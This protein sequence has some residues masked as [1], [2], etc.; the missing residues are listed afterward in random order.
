MAFRTVFWT[1]AFAA[2]FLLSGR[3]AAQGMALD[4]CSDTAPCAENYVCC[5]L[6]DVHQWCLL[7]MS[8]VRHLCLQQ[9]GPKCAPKD[10]PCDAN[11]PWYNPTVDEGEVAEGEVADGEE[12]EGEEAEGVLAEDASA[13][14]G[15]PDQEQSEAEQPEEQAPA[16]DNTTDAAEDETQCVDSST[17]A[18]GTVCCPASAY[19]SLCQASCN[20]SLATL[21]ADC[22]I[23]KGMKGRGERASGTTL[24]TDDGSGITLTPEVCTGATVC[25]SIDEGYVVTKHLC[26]G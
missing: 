14:E 24:H 9:Q 1:C 16:D 22:F 19:L 12:A 26:D 23:V 7:F 18:A 17:C 21:Y 3:V 2:L 5:T 13:A 10:Q 15:Q 25:T 8:M 6:A 20:N 4:E 11:A